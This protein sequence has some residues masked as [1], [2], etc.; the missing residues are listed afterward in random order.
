MS[1]KKCSISNKLDGMEDD[2]VWDSHPDH[3]SSV[4][5]NDNKSIREEHL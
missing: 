2:Y 3:V 4:D 5:D 1:F